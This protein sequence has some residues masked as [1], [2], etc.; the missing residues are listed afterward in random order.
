MMKVLTSI[1]ILVALVIAE[2]AEGWA[3]KCA[4]VH[5]FLDFKWCYVIFKL[6]CTWGL[7]C[8]RRWDVYNDFKSISSDDLCNKH[9]NEIKQA[10]KAYKSRLNTIA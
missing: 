10:Y 3:K 1:I 6:K 8:V 2:D 4:D 7:N 9:W 5:N